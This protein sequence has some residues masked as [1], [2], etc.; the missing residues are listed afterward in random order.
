M[1]EVRE[2]LAV[3]AASTTSSV[4]HPNS[5][6][7]PDGKR[8]PGLLTWRPAAGDTRS[9]VGRIGSRHASGRRSGAR[10]RVSG[11]G[12]GS[13]V[14]AGRQLVRWSA[15][16]WPAID[17]RWSYA[18]RCAA[19]ACVCRLAGGCWSAVADHSSGRGRCGGARGGAAGS[20]G[21]AAVVLPRPRR[22][23]SARRAP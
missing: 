7:H 21:S 23:G 17:E 16:G 8:L 1:R 2:L 3:A 20:G 5:V 11:V 15:V 18:G 10:G 4:G 19:V 13:F 6:G 22:G 14:G 9:T 12:R